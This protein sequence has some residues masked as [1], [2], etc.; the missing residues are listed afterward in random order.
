MEF[1]FGGGFGEK[2]LRGSAEAIFVIKLFGCISISKAKA[3]SSK[4]DPTLLIIDF[5]V[6]FNNGVFFPFYVLTSL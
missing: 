5:R 2:E 4:N 1:G 6:I 3:F